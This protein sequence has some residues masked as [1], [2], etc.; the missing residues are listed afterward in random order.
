MKK[1]LI[2]MAAM[3]TALATNARTL[4]VYYSYTSNVHRIACELQARTGADTVRIQPAEKGL[5][6]EADN[7][8]LGS[9]LISAIRNNPDDAS[10]Y[11]AI[12][13]VNVD[14]SRYDTL[15][16]GAPLWWSDMAAPL[17][18]YLFHHGAEMAGKKIG[19]FVSSASSGIS[20][21][22]ADARRLVPGGNFLSPSLWVRS[23]QVSSCGAMLDNWLS[24]IGFGKES[25]KMEIAVNGHR[26][27][28]SL[29]DNSSAKALLQLLREG[30]VTVNA[31]EYGGFEM[32][33]ALPQ[34]LPANDEQ[35]NTVPGDIIL[36]QGRSICFY[37]GNNSWNFT[38]LGKIDN[39]GSLDLRSIFGVSAGNA[40]FVLSVSNGAAN[41]VNDGED[42]VVTAVYSPDGRRIASGLE[43]LGNGMYIVYGQ[44]AD[45]TMTS[46]KVFVGR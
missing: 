11:P 39:A 35:I 22:E 21:V 24:Q 9:A 23:A 26:L 30:S 41:S 14:L 17:Q 6:Y 8:A 34:S 28:A 25:A 44:K 29:A 1:I 3:L 45:G 20:G 15:F 4:I 12:D 13:P 46:K 5:H 16:I 18:T 32:V 10:S 2:L 27:T 42:F 37:Y 43:G 38:R 33:G 7:Y 19:L 36:Y 31:S 40:T